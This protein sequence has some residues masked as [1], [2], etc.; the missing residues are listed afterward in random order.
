MANTSTQITTNQRTLGPVSDLERH[1]PTE[2][3][4]GLFNSL[5]LKT[6][7]DVVE[8]NDN[9]KN[10]VNTLI[11]A[12]ALN[13]SDHILDLCCGQGRHALELASRG[14]NHVTGIDRSRYL[15]R[16]ARKRAA[17]AGVQVKFSE[18]DARKIRLPENSQQAVYLMGNSFG[19]FEHEEDDAALLKAVKR[20]LVS[21]GKI[22]L[23]ITNG[24]WIRDHYSPRSWEWIDQNHFVCR[25]RSLSS[26]QSK[27]VSR[28]VIVHAEKGVITD[29]FYAERLYDEKQI[30]QLLNKLGFDHVKID[31]NIG[32]E[33]TRGH[34][35]GMMENRLF[36]TAIAPKKI[37]STPKTKKKQPIT[38]LLGDPRLPDSVKK[39]GIFNSEDLETVDRLKGNLSKMEEFNF[40][41]CDH[42]ANFI[43]YLQTNKP[44]FVLNFCDEGYKNDAL[45]ELHVPALLEMLDIPYS[46]A[47]PAALAL[48]YDKAVIRALALSLDI[49]V[50]EETYYHPSD[51]AASIPSIFPAIL[52]PNYGD[53]SIGITKDAIVHDAESLITSLDALRQQLPNTAILIQEFLEGHEYSVGIIGNPGNYK[54]LPILEVDYS[55]LPKD[56]P[57]ILGYESKWLPDSHYWKDIA[58]IEA[59]LEEE[60]VR[61]LIDAATKLFER[62][63]CR[64][65]ARFDFRANKE[66]QIKL[67]EI[68]PNPGWCWDG[69]LNLMAE[70]AGYS[71][72]DLLCM[73]IEAALERHHYLL[74]QGEYAA[75]A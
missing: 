50:P 3:W 36:V 2:W 1:L 40:H 45:K 7:G 25:E 31:K 29:Q 52:K 51:H 70:Y 43:S 23:D 18:G 63:G 5:Y 39:N 37:I 54:V 16:L 57:R 11:D 10:D 15:I 8:N 30:C 49:A 44:E 71:Y 9:T 14:F 19:Y 69:K 42:H 22:A 41:Y 28:E 13:K 53:S 33:S 65:Y 64:D 34:D 58:Y 75:A 38:V 61:K 67:L 17:G 32:S 6:D 27:I 55:K 59:N 56:L 26:D 12:L 66:G 60:A 46:G 48:C 20:I 4:K 68:N 72:Q 35:L 62:T 74:K 21:R 73:I 47:T 24:Q